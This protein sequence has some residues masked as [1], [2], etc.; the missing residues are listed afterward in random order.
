MLYRTDGY[1]SLPTGDAWS[2]SAESAA[3]GRE[4]GATLPPLTV[5]ETARLAVWFCLLWFVA[6]WTVTAAV[7]Y[8]SVSSMSILSSVS[9][10]SFIFNCHGTTSS[11]ARRTGFFTIAIGRLF[12]VEALTKGKILAAVCR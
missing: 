7:R 11:T 10:T 3:L 5:E 8:T 1:L 2:D 12:H 9:S 4:R 6:N